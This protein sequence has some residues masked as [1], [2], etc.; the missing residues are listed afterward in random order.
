MVI[1]GQTRSTMH[2]CPLA[3]PLAGLWPGPWLALDLSLAGPW[4]GPWLA[5]GLALGWP[6][7]GPWPGPWLAL[8]LAFGLA[9]GLALVGSWLG[10]WLGLSIQTSSISNQFQFRLVLVRASSGPNWF[11]S[12]VSSSIRSHPGSFSLRIACLRFRFHSS[13]PTV[14]YVDSFDFENLGEPEVE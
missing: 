4:P 9:L 13:N 8:G 5:L 7:V 11:D 10:P 2:G 6:L 12:S 14:S 1:R 3:W